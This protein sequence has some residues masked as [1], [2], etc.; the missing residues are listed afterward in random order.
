MPSYVTPIPKGKHGD[1][2]FFPAWKVLR[3]SGENVTPDSMDNTAQA[4]FGRRARSLA[5]AGYFLG[6]HEAAPAGDTIEIVE[7]KLG[8]RSQPA[9]LVVRA[10][11]RFCE[12]YAK[13]ERVRIPADRL[14]KP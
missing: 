11:A 6:G 2:L 9:G 8:S 1:H 7:R 14:L 5:E 12:A 10:T 13:G 3:V 4:R